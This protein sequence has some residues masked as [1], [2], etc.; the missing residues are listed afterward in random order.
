MLLKTQRGVR[1]NLMTKDVIFLCCLILL[2]TLSFFNISYYLFPK[3]NSGDNQI[4]HSNTN[5]AVVYW[6]ELLESHP[7]YFFGWIEL[8]ELEL[9]SG[10]KPKAIEALVQANN[11]NPNSQEVKTIS[12]DIGFKVD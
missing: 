7:T 9:M 10:N 6:Q 4:A 3:K 1:L 2:I 8:A 5:Q 12:E 11:I